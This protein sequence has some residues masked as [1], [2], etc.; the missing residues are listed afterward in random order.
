MDEANQLS[1]TPLFIRLSTPEGRKAFLDIVDDSKLS[2]AELEEG[3]N[4]WAERQGGKVLVSFAI[5][6]TQEEFKRQKRKLAEF[7]D[8]FSKLIS[9]SSLSDEAKLVL[10]EMEA[11]PLDKTLTLAEESH[12]MKTALIRL[13]SLPVYEEIINF[14]ADNKVKVMQQGKD[15][16]L[17]SILQC[18]ALN[19][20][21]P[22]EDDLAN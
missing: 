12:Q 5:L 16:D 1:L 17:L 9:E 14:M 2:K 4:A 6:Y 8:A 15:A 11:I 3:V 18:S 22:T 20:L 10:Q 19:I 7:N 21:E 13:R